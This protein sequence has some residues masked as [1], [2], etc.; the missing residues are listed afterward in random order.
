MEKPLQVIRVWSQKVII[1]PVH[2]KQEIQEELKVALPILE[3]TVVEEYKAHTH[4]YIYIYIYSGNYTI[5]EITCDK[6]TQKV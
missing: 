4:I 2:A 1:Y 6:I 3:P 5:T